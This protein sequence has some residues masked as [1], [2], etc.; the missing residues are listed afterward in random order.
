[1]KLLDQQLMA[2]DFDHQVA[3]VQVRVAI[4]NGSP[5]LASLSR[6]PCDKSVWGKESLV[7]MLICATAPLQAPRVAEDDLI[8]KLREANALNSTKIK[9]VVLETR[10]DISVLHGAYMED[11][12]FKGVA[13]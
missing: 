2:R 1:M 3:E 6:N 4:L 11:I 10:R 12:L 5:P 7:R 9:A 13:Y 8:A